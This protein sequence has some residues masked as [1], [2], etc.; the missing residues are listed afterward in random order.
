M[1]RPAI[2]F[3]NELSYSNSEMWLNPELPKGKGCASNQPFST[4]PFTVSFCGEVFCGVKLFAKPPTSHLSGLVAWL[5][6]EES[7]FSVGGM[8]TFYP[9]RR[10][11]FISEVLEREVRKAI[12][13]PHATPLADADLNSKIGEALAWCT[14]CPK[15]Q[16]VDCVASRL[17][18]PVSCPCA[19]RL[20]FFIC[21]RD[22]IILTSN[23][24]SQRLWNP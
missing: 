13:L 11:F 8:T 17:L 12:T 21:C 4:R 6:W 16:M 5:F 3:F 14:S 1:R 9:S 18:M 2:F 24:V 7:D 22:A 23:A 15:W 20:L 19:F 10:C